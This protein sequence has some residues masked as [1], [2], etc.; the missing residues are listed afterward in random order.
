LIFI[1]IL[2]HFHIYLNIYSFLWKI[3]HRALKFIFSIS[4]T[5]IP[6]LQYYKLIIDKYKFSPVWIEGS[7]IIIDTFSYLYIIPIDKYYIIFNR[8]MIMIDFNFFQSND[9]IIRSR[10]YLHLYDFLFLNIDIDHREEKSEME[11]HQSIGSDQLI[12]SNQIHRDIPLL[13]ISELISIQII[14]K[15]R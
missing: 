10:L 13:D 11:F 9:W 6:I 4:K 15:I 1:W 7:K 2:D 5:N 8:E 14:G 12:G 3:D